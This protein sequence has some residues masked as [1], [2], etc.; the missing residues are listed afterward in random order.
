MERIDHCDRFVA[1]EADEE[2]RWKVRPVAPP[3]LCPSDVDVEDAERDG[4]ALSPVD[5]ARQVGVLHV[6]VGLAV[7][8]VAVAFE[9]YGVYGINLLFE[10]I[11]AAHGLGGLHGKPPK[12]LAIG[13][14]GGTGTI[15]RGKHER[16]L[17]EIDSRIVFAADAAQRFL[18]LDSGGHGNIHSIARSQW[19]RPANAGVLYKASPD[20][21]RSVAYPQYIYQFLC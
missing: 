16:R 12:V 10:R 11:G 5:D 20:A 17:G 18:D 1:L 3:A 6:V 13:V 8:P 9:E 7:A 15:E 2:M 4:E 21:L 19:R 14:D